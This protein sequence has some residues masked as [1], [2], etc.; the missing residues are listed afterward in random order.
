MSD[1]GVIARYLEALGRGLRVGPRRKARI[2]AEVEDHLC[3]AVRE[4]Q[5]RGASAAD[6]WDIAVAR[7]GA[8]GMVARQF[9]A[10]LAFGGVRSAAR[11]LFI[12]ILTFGFVAQI[13]SPIAG[14]IFGAEGNGL[15]APGGP[16]PGDV[17]PW[18]LQITVT[19]ADGALAVAFGAV[20]FALVQTHLWRRGITITYPEVQLRISQRGMEGAALGATVFGAAALAVSAIANT[21]WSF[22]RAAAVPHSPTPGVLASIAV[23]HALALAIGLGYVVRAVR[24]A[25]AAVDRA[26]TISA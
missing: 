15:F 6:A 4:E 19:I 26:E 8:P 7:F 2:L 16:W 10:E 13:T 22:Q 12:V 24:W 17:P 1:T 25:S 9:M 23:V 3:E 18:Q 20:L 5:E 21:V 11:A 14:R